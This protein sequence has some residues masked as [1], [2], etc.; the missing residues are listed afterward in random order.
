[1][2]PT[3]RERGRRRR[4]VEPTRRACGRR[5][6]QIE[7]MRRWEKRRKGKLNRRADPGGRRDKSYREARSSHGEVLPRAR[8]A[9]PGSAVSP[10]GLG[11][12]SPAQTLMRVEEEGARSLPGRRPSP[13]GPER[14]NP[15]PPGLES[16]PRPAGVERGH[17][18]KPFYSYAQP[19]ACW[20]SVSRASSR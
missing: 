13:R 18:R 6:R 11:P 2:E 10:L 7:P 9:G 4:Q 3:R 15:R 5:Q 16:P 19:H 20:R 1:V 8:G 14:A 17:T 12:E